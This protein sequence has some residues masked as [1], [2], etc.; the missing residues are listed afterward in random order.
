[1]CWEGREKEITFVEETID[2]GP[3]SI[4]AY[5]NSRDNGADIGIC[6]GGDPPRL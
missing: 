2:N 5:G 4:L 6:S 3:G 1:M